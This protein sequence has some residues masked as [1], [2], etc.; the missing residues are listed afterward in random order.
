MRSLFYVLFT[1]F[2]ASLSLFGQTD[3]ILEEVDQMPLYKAVCGDGE[4]PK[5]CADRAMLQYVY[6]SIVYPKQAVAKEAEGMVVIS[7][8]VEKNGMIS[9]PTIYRDQVGYGAGEEVLRIV[10][11]MNDNNPSWK[12]GIHEGKPVRVEYKLPVKFKLS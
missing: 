5:F 12:P 11:A 8:V 2:I 3:P 6:S 9:N 10:R 7:F 1:F 4:D